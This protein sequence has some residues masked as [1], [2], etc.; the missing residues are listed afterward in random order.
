MAM[1]AYLRSF[2]SIRP[3]LIVLA[4]ACALAALLACGSAATPVPEPT[5]APTAAAAPTAAP[6][7][8]ATAAPTA[9]ETTSPPAAAATSRPPVSATPAPAAAPTSAP[10]TSAPQPTASAEENPIRARLAT[11]VLELGQQRV[12]FLLADSK[13]IIQDAAVTITPV[14]TGDNSAGPTVE[15][16]FHLWPYGS[17]GSYSADV[18]FDRPGEWRLDVDVAA[19]DVSGRVEIEINVEEQSPVPGL[20]TVAP[21]SHTKTLGTVANIEK[22]TTDYSPDPDLYQLSIAE[23]IENPLPSVIVFASPAFC[24]T[25]TCGPQVD[26]VSELK[27]AH[28]GKANFIH[29]EIYDNPDEIQ[30]DLSRGEIAPSVDEWGLSALPHWFNESWTFVLD[31]EGRVRDRFEGF[32][33][34]TELEDALTEVLPGA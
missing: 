26:A 31:D 24:T 8:A 16:E 15:T 19:P 25:A 12:A 22:L 11:T 10:A 14:Y 23:A 29:V 3:L 27:N 33:S 30:G 6:A 34:Y 9:A 2:T 28:Q 1:A 4:G 7:A 21:M 18:L 20:G 32:A 17:R 5:L 13:G